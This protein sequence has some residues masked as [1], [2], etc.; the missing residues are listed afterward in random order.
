MSEVELLDTDG[1]DDEEI[2]DLR[3]LVDQ[4]HIEHLTVDPGIYEER[5]IYSS[6][7]LEMA[8]PPLPQGQWNCAHISSDPTTG[9]PYFSS[10]QNLPLPGITNLWHPI[11]IDY[12]S[13]KL[14]R[15]LK[16]RVQE[17]TCRYFEGTVVVKLARFPWEIP[18]LEQETQAYEWIKDTDIGPTFLAHLTEEG[19]TIG[20]VMEHIA[21]AHHAEP[22]EMFSC[23][24]ALERL[25]K[26]GIQHGNVNKYNIL[27]REE[28]VTLID[29]ALCDTMSRPWASGCR[30]RLARI[31]TT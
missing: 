20:F 28:Y 2:T 6:I 11:S 9:R 16:S 15:K 23:Q 8:L 18:S 24:E 3:I 4:K 10:V 7:S 17:A 26:L 14:D 19:R 31:R 12:L 22:E 21:Y 13:L 30:A 29:F 25:H 27:I 1:D 5:M